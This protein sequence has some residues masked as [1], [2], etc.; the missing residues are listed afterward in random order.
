MASPF[1]AAASRASLLACL[2]RESSD[3]RAGRS[4]AA[5]IAPPFTERLY[6]LSNQAERRCTAPRFRLVTGGNAS[7]AAGGRRPVRRAGKEYCGGRRRCQTR[8][9]RV[10]RLILMFTHDA[11]VTAPVYLTNR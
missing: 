3:G 9:S 1:P 7:L 6:P 5:D 2:R 4:R 8:Q 10:P 11:A